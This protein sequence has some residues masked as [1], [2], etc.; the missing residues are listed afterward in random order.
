MLN[1]IGGFCLLI[2]AIQARMYGF[3]LLEG[4][5]T[6]VSA[7]GVWRMARSKSGVR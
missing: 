3:I 5:W 7:W 4:S 2:A 1:L 6:V